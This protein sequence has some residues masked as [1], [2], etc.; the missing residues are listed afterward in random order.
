MT[1]RDTIMMLPESEQL[2]YA[3]CWLETLLPS[4]FDDRVI[5]VTQ[6][7]SV[8][9]SE[10]RVLVTMHESHPNHV[11]R[12]MLHAATGCEEYVDIKI[13]DVFVSKI[14]KT[15]GKDVIETLWGQGYR[16]TERLQCLSSEA[17][18]AP[19]VTKTQT[20]SPPTRENTKRSWT[21]QDLR[22]LAR[23]YRKRDDLSTIAEEL[24]R[25]ERACSEKI[26]SLLNG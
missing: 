22:D 4:R 14:R 1:P 18:R 12:E 19:L 9:P 11:T 26:R 13:V 2:E 15:L 25:T 16:L 7:H 10:A 24:G 5:A 23:M 17:C 21:A 20:V 8:T 6:A 3:V